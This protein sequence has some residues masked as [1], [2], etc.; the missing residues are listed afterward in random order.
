MHSKAIIV[1]CG[2][3]GLSAAICLRLIG[4]HVRV[5]EQATE[6]TEV[7]AGVHPHRDVA[8][9]RPAAGLCAA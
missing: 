7:G 5:L 4:W 6:I 1:G 3:G 9:N 8:R 2:V